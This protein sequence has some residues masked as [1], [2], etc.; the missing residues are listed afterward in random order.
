VLRKVGLEDSEH[1]QLSLSL[2]PIVAKERF[3]RDH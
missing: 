1:T 2:L 3:V